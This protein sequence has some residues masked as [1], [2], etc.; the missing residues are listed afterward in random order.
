MKQS[1]FNIPGMDCAAEEQVIRLALDGKDEVRGLD[2]DLQARQLKVRHTGESEAILKLLLPTGFGAEISGVS[3]VPD[4]APV[5][6]LSQDEQHTGAL[7]IVFW[8]NFG[9]F[10]IGL[11]AGVIARSM[12]LVADSLDMLAD[13]SVF[14][15]SLYAIGKTAQ[16]K[17]RAALLSG[18]LQFLVA[19]GVLVEVVRKFI[20][21]SEPVAGIMIGVAAVS[22]VANAYCMKVLSRHKAGEVH[23]QASWIFLSNDVFANAGVILAGIL[24]RLTASRYPDLIIG[25]IIAAVVFMGSF[26][27]LKLSR[28]A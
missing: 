10:L 14:A 2:F 17:K 16:L 24:V 5:E 15:L 23:M 12:G 21:G 1:V 26:K 28:A 4:G 13:A 3:E 11:V 19:L 6:S 7:K 27:I 25:M 9:M 20:Y 8:I 18:L 22:L